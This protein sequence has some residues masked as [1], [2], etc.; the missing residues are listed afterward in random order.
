MNTG[1]VN[2]LDGEVRKLLEKLPGR[3]SEK[4]AFFRDRFHLTLRKSGYDVLW[5]DLGIPGNLPRVKYVF[6]YAKGHLP[7][8]VRGML[9][10][11][12]TGPAK[13]SVTDPQLADLLFFQNGKLKKLGRLLLEHL[14][15]PAPAKKATA[16]A[17][18]RPKSAPSPTTRKSVPAAV[19][20]TPAR[21]PVNPEDATTRTSDGQAHGWWKQQQRYKPEGER[22]GKGGMAFVYRV[23]DLKTREL[24]A[25]KVIDP[26]H[27][28]D[29]EYQ[30]RFARE[31]RAQSLLVHRHVLRILDHGRD[32]YVAELCPQ[33]LKDL[34]NKGQIPRKRA[35]ALF[36]HACMGVEHA[37]AHRVLHRDLKPSN[38]LLRKGGDL[39]VADF[40]LC[41]IDSS[42]FTTMTSTRAQGGTY[43]YAAPEQWVSL[44]RAD[45]RADV[46]SLG[47][48][49]QD[50][51]VGDSR[52]T[53]GD[54][55]ALTRVKADPFI[56]IVLKATALSPNERFS[57]VAE[58]RAAAE[59]AAS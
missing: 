4:H 38:M 26:K 45:H 20:P 52:A 28:K 8:K 27:R 25:A 35:L 47:I 22:L 6:D 53:A 56:P 41:R 2:G 12:R 59:R 30:E 18:S 31:V 36:V 55:R 58:L 19:K 32:F 23:R 43:R 39:V 3:V 34:L 17:K 49:L 15:A 1:D 50:L 54:A 44:H 13:R 5:A 21:A 42:D 57:T 48:V 9:D 14:P 29:L 7:D 51:L 37:H 11:S 46:F 16:P 24:R 40:G 33:S 10:E